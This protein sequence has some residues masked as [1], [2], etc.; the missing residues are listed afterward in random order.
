MGL[1]KL[2]LLIFGIIILLVLGVAF[3]F[4]NFY[5]FETLTICVSNQAEDTPIPC[6]TDESCISQF[7]TNNAEIG[8]SLEDA[9][10]FFKETANKVIEEAVF[11]EDT[12]KLKEIYGDLGERQVESCSQ[13]DKDFSI[14]L[15]GKEALEAYRFVKEKGLA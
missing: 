15:R 14:E 3:Y 6:S 10:G 11:C 13:G 12:C 7:L 5:V 8:E 2:L 1:L 9:P 4:Y